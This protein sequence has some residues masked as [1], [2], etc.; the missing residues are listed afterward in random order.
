MLRH[1]QSKI[2]FLNIVL[3][4]NE[5]ENEIWLISKS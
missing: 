3:N 2:K 5:D 4:D 1:L